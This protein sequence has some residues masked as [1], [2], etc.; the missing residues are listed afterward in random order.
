M[1]KHNVILIICI[2]LS[3]CA[4]LPTY[5]GQYVQITDGPYKGR[6]GK[7]IGDCSWFENYKVRLNTGKDV[8]IKS[9]NM[10]AAE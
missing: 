10:K 4:N 2:F 8:C 5:Y 9:W 1:M 7:L 6:T 3:G